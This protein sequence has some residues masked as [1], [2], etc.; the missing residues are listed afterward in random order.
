[1]LNL[2]KHK[3][4]Q[5]S[6]PTGEYEANKI[7]NLNTISSGT[8]YWYVIKINKLYKKLKIITNHIN[9]FK[10]LFSNLFLKTMKRSIG[11]NK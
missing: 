10:Y 5:T 2:K 7:C 4:F 6:I 3:Y 1:M 9:S 8:I 11:N